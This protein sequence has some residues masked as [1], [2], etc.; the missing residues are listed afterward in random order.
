M[1]IVSSKKT[2]DTILRGAGLPDAAGLTL[3]TPGLQILWLKEQAVLL[4][5]RKP[6]RGGYF[7][8]NGERLVR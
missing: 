8:F 7:T 4:N 1:G 5:G 3:I 6:L 2:E